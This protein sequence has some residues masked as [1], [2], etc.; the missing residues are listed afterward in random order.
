[1]NEIIFKQGSIEDLDLIKPLWEKLNQLHFEL[2]ENFKSRFRNKTWDIRKHDLLTKSREILIDYA[3]DS[4]NSII[5]YCI[6]TIDKEDEGIGEID[7]IYVDGV[8]RKT[9]IGKQLMDRAI[10]WLIS[11]ETKIQ[12]LDVGAGNERVLDFYKQFDFY[13]INTV[14]QRIEKNK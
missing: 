5:G 13:P 10:E 14:L 11:K 6:S 12:R 3:I 1:M 2:S 7:S 9:G 4:S 8:Y